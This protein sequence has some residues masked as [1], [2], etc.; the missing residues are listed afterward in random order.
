MTW[1]CTARVDTVKPDVLA[2]M[3]KADCW[4]ISFGLETGSNELLQKMKKAAR[5]EISERAINW[6]ATAGI[7]CKGL[8]ML[9]YPSET[10]ET[11]AQTKAFVKRIPMTTMNLSKF[12]P[13]PGSPIYRDNYSANI[14]KEHWEKMNGMNFVWVADGLTVERLDQEYQAILVSFYKQRRIAHKYVVMTFQHPAH[15]SRLIRF[16][17]GYFWAKVRNYW[18][19]KKAF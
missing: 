16:L 10:Y 12:T 2:K 6:T 5:V 19:G 3:K 7:R 15:L 11:I 1:S 8:F 18:N 4:E 14:C 17:A 13:Y 9:G